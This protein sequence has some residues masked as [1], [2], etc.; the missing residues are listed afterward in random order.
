MK[1][2]DRLHSPPPGGGTAG[3]GLFQA[4]GGER[5]YKRFARVI[6]QRRKSRC[7]TRRNRTDSHSPPLNMP[8]GIFSTPLPEGG[9]IRGLIIRFQV[10]RTGVEPNCPT[11]MHFRIFR[12]AFTR[13]IGI[14]LRKIPPKSIKNA[15]AGGC[16]AVLTKQIFSS[17]K[18]FPAGHIGNMSKGKDE[19][20]GQI[21]TSKPIWF[22]FR[23]A[24]ENL[25]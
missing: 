6:S 11:T 23:S 5:E 19:G 1:G 14:L 13:K 4:Q 12:R 9:Y 15:F 8:C 20:I 2:R 24:K 17:P 21:C 18:A 3:A 22:D 10:S 16:Y 25:L 7:K